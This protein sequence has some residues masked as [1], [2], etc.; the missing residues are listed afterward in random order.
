MK[1]FLSCAGNFQVS[2]FIYKNWP[3][4]KKTKTKS[5][6]KTKNKT[7]VVICTKTVCHFDD[8]FCHTQ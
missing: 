1:L 5:K 7:K 4:S 6:T 3:K 8:G 2:K